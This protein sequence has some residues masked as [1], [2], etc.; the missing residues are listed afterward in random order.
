LTPA[1]LIPS[2]VTPAPSGPSEMEVDPSPQDASPQQPPSPPLP[3][4]HLPPLRW[5]PPSPLLP[6]WCRFIP[7]PWSPFPPR[8]HQPPRPPPL[9]HRHLRPPASPTGMAQTLTTTFFTLI[10]WSLMPQPWG[11]TW[12][13]VTA[14]PWF[15]LWKNFIRL[16]TP[17]PSSHMANWTPTNPSS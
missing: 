7:L 11:L 12:W 1:P 2:L 3:H 5:Q 8:P 10:W 15:V 6:N 4:Q 13:V 9:P 17:S 14:C 16:I